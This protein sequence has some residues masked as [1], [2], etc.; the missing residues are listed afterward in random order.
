MIKLTYSNVNYLLQDITSASFGDKPMKLDNEFI[1]NL[2]DECDEEDGDNTFTPLLG[3]K[4]QFT[5]DGD[6]KNDG[7]MVKYCFTFTHPNGAETKICT[8]M[9]LMV[10]FNY[11]EDV[12]FNEKPSKSKTKTRDTKNLKTKGVKKNQ[13][14]TRKQVEELLSE[15]ACHVSENGASLSVAKQ[16]LKDIYPTK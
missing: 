6:H 2:N 4:V 8:E 13:I 3:F 9:C 15:F 10:G 11:H 7:Q 12:I 5:T 16:W 1:T 14:F